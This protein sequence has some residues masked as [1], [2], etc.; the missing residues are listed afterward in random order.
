MDVDALHKLTLDDRNEESGVTVNQRALIDKVL[1]RY[2]SENTLLR[3]LMQNA[4]DANAT[5][6]R[7]TYEA[8]APWQDVNRAVTNRVIVRNNG[9][10]FRPE[11]WTRLARIAE[12]NPDESKIGAFGVGFYSVFSISDDPF[13]T[14]GDTGLAFYWRGDQLFTRRAKL[15]QAEE[16]TQFALKMRDHQELPNL[17]TLTKFL[18]TSLTFARSINHIEL[19]LDELCLC[20]LKRIASPVQPIE[21]RSNLATT[22]A[23]KMMR[24]TAV[25]STSVQI[26]ATYS[27]ATQ[28]L[29]PSTVSSRF[30]SFLSGK[31]P[32]PPVVDLTAT[33]TSTI[34]LR[35]VTGHIQTA[36]KTAFSAELLRAT[37][38]SPPRNTKIQLVVANAA[39]HAASS[40][41]ATVFEDL[42]CYP[43][44][45]RVYIGFPTHQTSGFSGHIGAPCLIPTVERESIDLVDR[46]V[47]V[48]NFEVLRAIGL[49]CRIA[50]HIEFL[51]VKDDFEAVHSMNFFGFRTAT[52][53]RI[54]YDLEEAFFGSSS[55]IP[56]FTTKG[57]K[58]S[59]EARLRDP[60]VTF[61]K[62]VP[63]LTDKVQS[64]ASEFI[65]KLKQLGLVEAINIGDI[66]GD[67]QSRI[68]AT[69]EAIAFLRYCAGR[70]KHLDTAAYLALIGAAV[71]DAAGKPVGVAT[72]K[73]YGSAKTIP[74]DVPMPPSCAPS[75]LTAAL[76]TTEMHNLGWSELPVIQWLEFCVAVEA[77]GKPPEPDV[78]K[79]EVFAGQVLAVMSKNFDALSPAD[80]ARTLEL[81]QTK[82]CIPTRNHGM[83]RPDQAYLFS[84]K[85]FEDL[86]VVSSL[87]GVKEKF[88]VQLGV[89][90]TIEL[91]IIFDKL[92]KG[93]QW[94]THDVI[95]YLASVSKD[96]PPRDFERLKNMPIASGES[97]TGTRAKISSFYEPNETLRSLGLPVL[98]WP[99]DKWRPLSNESN[100]LFELGLKRY[101]PVDVLLRLCGGEDPVLRERALKYFLTNFRSYGYGA[102]YSSSKVPCAFVPTESG[103]LREPDSVFTNP[104][105]AAF[106]FEVLRRDLLGASA[107]LLGVQPFPPP[108]TLLSLIVRSPPQSY[109]VAV[110]QFAVLGQVVTSPSKSVASENIIPVIRDD[111]LI[112]HT[113]PNKA[114]FRTV[115]TESWFAQVFDV[116]D[117]GPHA[118]AFLRLVG[119]RDKPTT[120]QLTGMLVRDPEQVLTLCASEERYRDLLAQVARDVDEVKR[121]GHL[122]NTM[123]S[124]RVLLAIR[125]KRDDS[126]NPV[127]QTSLQSA[128]DVL[129]VDE[130]I[131]F[132]LFRE[133][134]WTAPQDSLLESLY[135]A[136][137]AI[138]L[139]SVIQAQ[140]TTSGQPRVTDLCTS[141]K[142]HIL[143]R[144]PVFLYSENYKPKRDVKWI[145]SRLRVVQ[146]DSLSLR[147]VLRFGAI[148]SAKT[149]P[150]SALLLDDSQLCIV[151]Q[152]DNYDVAVAICRLVLS[153][154]RSRDY[155]LL[156]GLLTWGVEKLKARG[157]NVDRILQRRERE[158]KERILARE[159]EAEQEAVAAKQRAEAAERAREEK[160]QLQSAVHEVA[161]ISTPPPPP[162]QAAAAAARAVT[163]QSNTPTM[164]GA[165]PGSA[166]SG[167]LST[168]KRNLGLKSN[169]ADAAGSGSS[170]S[171]I[172]PQPTQTTQTT[173]NGDGPPATPAQVDHALDSALQAL[174][175]ASADAKLFSPPQVTQVRE[176]ASYC[177]ATAAHNL[178]LAIA[179]LAH[180]GG[181]PGSRLYASNIDGGQLSAFS[182]THGAAAA[183]FT[184]LLRRL[185]TAVFGVA[186]G[187]PACRALLNVFY[188]Q[189]GA[190]IAFNRGGTVYCNLR[191][192]VQ[193]QHDLDDPASPLLDAAQRRKVM[194]D[195]LGY[196]FVTLAH[197]LAHNLVKEHSARHAF[198]V[199]SAVCRYLPRLTVELARP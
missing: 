50:Y 49:L 160:K 183:R 149:T 188:D 150:L 61:L 69:T 109:A 194:A 66:K 189:D 54:D 34:F 7:I 180:L 159:L 170:G 42:L 5:S 166:G 31:K 143:E 26:T 18:A 45:G 130:V 144:L 40:N 184:L 87:K 104:T 178:T 29:P 94:S 74:G 140:P 58:P 108:E 9:H 4:D 196:W 70:A 46:S 127:V 168:I 67:L 43:N 121:D 113:S 152:P 77:F 192:F 174:R 83:R 139:G 195:A 97:T 177:D 114:F 39:E 167:F 134:V 96:I 71:I 64:G 115:T 112:R 35:V 138:R 118:N 72:L 82:T 107:S 19:Y 110:A 27:N 101:P 103:K 146:Y 158:K 123:R 151:G 57:V 86:P 81:L 191:Y 85:G 30:M 154:P 136:L 156:E 48:W 141:L 111:K 157:F 163:Q 190:T 162:P 131:D 137:G 84:I 73:H 78:R 52:P 2:S 133:D 186:D 22:T 161:G 145:E 187:S 165:F 197:E 55:V 63:L 60:E 142:Q 38:K 37:K 117:F 147:R 169:S 153:V 32:E 15:P 90:R 128:R 25:D 47:K 132:Q 129:I 179:D 93:G 98:A 23:G 193:L 44:Q 33:T 119:V 6:I 59:N 164:P 13:V 106:G 11:D 75:A 91:D 51:N 116:V 100:L 65:G 95:G 36:I 99:T 56:L 105:V 173:A 125:Y 135:A 102:T 80:R 182:K 175:P 92:V 76:S 24:I 1:A 68:L 62:E 181:A 17:R 185:A 148:S 41:K 199:E 171:Q 155:L 172:T 79:D 88:L 12:G 16:W 10:V 89:R 28:T 3:E 53:Q 126:G 198:Y 20:S 176:A 120:S 122:F 14:S 21:I 8:S 124:A